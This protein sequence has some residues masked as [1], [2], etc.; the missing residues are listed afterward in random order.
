MQS[1][2]YALN[3]DVLNVYVPKITLQRLGG[4]GGNGPCYTLFNDSKTP[5]SVNLGLYDLIGLQAIPT[6]NRPQRSHEVTANPERRHLRTVK[7]IP[8]PDIA[9][10]NLFTLLTK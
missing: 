5:F 9:S 2:W 3:Y 6:Q 7:D 4:G 1:Y 8:L 10:A